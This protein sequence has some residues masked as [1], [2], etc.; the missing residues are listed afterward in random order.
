MLRVYQVHEQS[1]ACVEIPLCM[2]VQA[3][4]SLHVYCPVFCIRSR[5]LASLT[6]C[7]LL[8]PG[9]VSG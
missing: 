4:P 2:C 9:L 3:C 7:P 5:C 6:H 8:G 1:G